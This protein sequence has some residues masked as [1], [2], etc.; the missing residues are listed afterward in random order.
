MSIK[1]KV[2]IGADPEFFVINK[3]QDQIVPSCDRFG[4]HKKSPIF[5]CPD[6][7][8]LEDGAAVE[9]NVTPASSLKELAKKME[10]L[11]TVFHTTHPNFLI[12]FQ[13][14]HKFDKL[15]IDNNPKMNVIGCDAD[16]WAWG[17]RDLPNIRQFKGWRFAGGHIHV[18]I[19]PWPAGLEKKTLIKYLDSTCW[20]KFLRFSDP[21]RYPFYGYPGLYRET[22]YGVEWRSPDNTWACP[23]P[24]NKFRADFINRFDRC[25]DLLIKGLS[26]FE[27]N[28]VNTEIKEFLEQDGT[29]S[30]LTTKPVVKRTSSWP[31]FSTSIPGTRIIEW[32]SEI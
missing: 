12:A 20:I 13:S 27:P 21:K 19:D 3:L 30:Y 1:Y 6:G 28:L 15:V 22:D 14:S 18:G 11:I 26:K 4:G 24:G 8:Y 16:L 10:S 2:T 32:L 23:Q 25:M 17:L 7:G 5:L 31:R 9:F 29:E